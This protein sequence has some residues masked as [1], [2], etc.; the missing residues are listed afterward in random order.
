MILEQLFSAANKQKDDAMRKR[1][2]LLIHHAPHSLACLW[3]R[4]GDGDRDGVG[5]GAGGATGGAHE[6][7]EVEGEQCAVSQGLLSARRGA[8]GGG[9]DTQV[10]MPK[11]PCK[12][13]KRVL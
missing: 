9:D 8:A 7:E 6:S 2:E 10:C 3:W 5:A 4:S 11:E 1:A 12:P 13:P